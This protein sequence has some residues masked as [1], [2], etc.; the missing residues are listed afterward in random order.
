MTA[1]ET[2]QKIMEQTGTTLSDFE[3]YSSLGSSSNIC[4]MLSRN[5]LKVGTFV[6]M[7]ETMGFQ[8]IAQSGETD[9]EIIVDNE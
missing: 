5:D 3:K 7:L 4:Q 6:E 1:I 9:E 2:V 8:L